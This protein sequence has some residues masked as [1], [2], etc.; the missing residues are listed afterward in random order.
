MESVIESIDVS[1]I[2]EVPLLMQKEKLDVIALKK[3]NLPI[4]EE[5]QLKPWKQFM[6]KLLNPKKQIKIGL[7][8]KYVEL[9]D[10]Y[11]SIVESFIHAG[12]ANDCEVNVH[13]IQPQ[14]I[15]GPHSL[16]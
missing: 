12:V 7:I 3:L 5:P 1:T 16:G 11:K 14:S 15:P 13:W 2:Y 8:G 6:D 4:S 9:H 10:S